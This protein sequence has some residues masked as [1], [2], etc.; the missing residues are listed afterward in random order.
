MNL[1][2]DAGQSLDLRI[3]ADL[4]VYDTV[5]YAKLWVHVRRVKLG[6]DPWN[7]HS[8]L[9]G[10]LARHCRARFSNNFGS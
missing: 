4:A 9:I 8:C 1:L 5:N 3:L 10:S 2:E 6:G 7:F